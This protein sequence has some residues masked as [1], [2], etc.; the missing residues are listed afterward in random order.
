MDEITKEILE[1]L[2]AQGFNI[3]SEKLAEQP[4]R[5]SNSPLIGPIV[6]GFG[7]I[8]NY[9]MPLSWG[10]DEEKVAV[11]REAGKTCFKNNCKKAV[12]ITESAMKQSSHLPE[13]PSEMPLSYPPSMRVDCLILFYFDFISPI[14]NTLR[15]FPFKILNN[16]LVRDPETDLSSFEMQSPLTGY[17]LMGFTAAAMVEE[18]CIGEFITLNEEINKELLSRVL[19]KYPGALGNTLD[20]QEEVS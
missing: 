6:F 4:D 11:I 16:K 2:I 17:F 1:A 19:I 3:A 14:N 12:M 20:P 5:D 10:D 15:M 13:D 8:R 18:M 9:V 7:D